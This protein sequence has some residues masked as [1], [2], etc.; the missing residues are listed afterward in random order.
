MGW[1][2]TDFDPSHP[3]SHGA[4]GRDFQK[5]EL[6]RLI[7]MGAAA[8]LDGEI[9]DADHADARAVLLAEE[10]HRARA[11][12]LVQIH[13]RARHGNVG[14]HVLVDEVLDLLDLTV[15]HTGAVREV[16]AEMIRRNERARLGDVRPED[17]AQ[18]RV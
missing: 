13:L 5:P 10:R 4:L 9:A 11:Q 6:A 1:T 2:L 15:L 3:G 14:L 7:Q 17:A 8:E 16:E 18:G 12:R